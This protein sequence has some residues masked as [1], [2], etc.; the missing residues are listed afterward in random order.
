MVTSPIDREDLPL[1][2][3]LTLLTHGPV[4]SPPTPNPMLTWSTMR[5]GRQGDD[6]VV[7]LNHSEILHLHAGGELVLTSG[8]WRTVCA[9]MP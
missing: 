6:V 1:V 9:R 8:G 4:P 7:K 5:G 2:T 3:L